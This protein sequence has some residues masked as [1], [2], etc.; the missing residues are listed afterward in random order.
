MSIMLSERL[1]ARISQLGMNVAEV[2][3]DADVNRSFVYDILRGRSQTPSLEKL[4]RVGDIVR[5]SP[6]WLLTGKGDIEG[7]DPITEDYHNDFVVI[8]SVSARASMGGGIQ[9]DHE[10]SR[11]RDYHFRRAWIRDRLGAAP[12]ML[13]IMAVDGDSM[14]PTLHAGDTVLVDLNQR[15]PKPPGV[16]VLNDGMGLVAKRLE[17][18]PMSDPPMIRIMSDNPQYTPYECLADEINIVGR[19][20]WFGREM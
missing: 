11:G 12:S 8:Q 15:S 5:A 18:I 1:R 10:P 4:K 2:A 20:R 19:V 16:F 17:Y 14:V 9:I 3:R 6:E 13:R 7:D